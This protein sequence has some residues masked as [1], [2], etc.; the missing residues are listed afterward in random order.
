MTLPAPRDPKSTHVALLMGGWSAE[1]DVSLS[2]GNECAKALEERRLQGNARGCGPRTCADTL[3]TL[4][5]DVVFNALHGRWGEDGCVQG[6]LEVLGIPY[7]HS[8][9]MASSV[10]MNKEQT[11]LHRGQGWRT[12]RRGP[13]GDACRGDGRPRVRAA[14][15]RQAHRGRL[16]RWRG[17][18]AG[19]GQPTARDDPANSSDERWPPAD[20]AVHCRAR[21]HLLHDRRTA[22]RT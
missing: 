19:G 16:Q 13:V 7:T 8:G 5:P 2:S 3:C 21:I 10:A 22:C 14:V 4:K 20:R 17:H 11:R 15:C 12:R 18:R 6:I 1:R 9:V